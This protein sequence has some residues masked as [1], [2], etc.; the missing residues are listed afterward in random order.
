MSKKKFKKFVK[1]NGAVYR[2]FPSGF[3]TNKPIPEDQW[4]RQFSEKQLNMFSRKKLLKIYNLPKYVKFKNDDGVDV[5]A[6]ISSRLYKKM[7]LKTSNGEK[8]TKL[9]KDLI[10]IS[11]IEA[12]SLLAI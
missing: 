9:S 1:E 3:R 11:E 8:V 2:A 12:K 7:I 4:M 6:E 5:V 10:P